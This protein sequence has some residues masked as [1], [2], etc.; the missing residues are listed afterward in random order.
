MGESGIIITAV[1]SLQCENR[2]LLGFVLC[3]CGW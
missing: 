2:L 3:G 1:P